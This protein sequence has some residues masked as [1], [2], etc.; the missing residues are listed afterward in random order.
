MEKKKKSLLKEMYQYRYIYFMLL[1][2]MLYYIIFHYIPMGG[3]VIAFQ[4]Y[5][6]GRGFLNS[7]WV[8]FK[9]FISFFNSI[10]FYR[11]VR[12]TLLLNF[13]QLIF[14]FPMPIVLALLINEVKGGFF[15]KFV[16]T[17]TYMP[18][19]ISVLVICGMILQ[20]SSTTGIFNDFRAL[21]GLERIPLL[22][23]K[24]MFRP[25]YI[26]SDIWQTVGW[27]SIIY[28]ATLS[29]IDPNLYEAAVIDGAGRLKQ[30]LYVTL[31][32]LFPVIIVQ[33]IMRIGRMMNLGHEKILL[34]Y[35][36]LT[37]ETSDVISTFVYR[38]G[39]IES[40]FSFGAAVGL[41]NSVISL[42]LIV[43][44]NTFS[45]KYLKESLW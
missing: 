42:I 26:I 17:V 2:L 4:N 39:I 20:F 38:R 34:L 19:F 14:S 27:S 44:A 24:S 3:V 37:Y 28:L 33:L 11:I 32:G 7:T 30:A 1:P 18:H 31:P 41:F 9:N 10:Y 29:G 13:Y 22:S 8:G 5:S 23:Q 36:P 25:I 21:L 15:K 45:K 16:Q 6:P 12:N 43:S 35:N 40:S